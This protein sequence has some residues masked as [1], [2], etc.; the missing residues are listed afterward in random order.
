M[1]FLSV[2]AAHVYNSDW[3]RLFLM[4]EQY[5]DILARFLET[6]LLRPDIQN[7]IFII[8]SDHGLQR[9]P[10]AMDYSLQVEHT[11]PWTELLIPESLLTPSKKALFENQERLT[12]GHDIYRTIR[13]LMFVD[14]TEK[15]YTCLLYTSPSPRDRG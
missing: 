11:R 3:S 14:E 7:T 4:A 10:M 8:R 15:P 9:G 12:S 5:D 2:L 13:S 6:M 1:A